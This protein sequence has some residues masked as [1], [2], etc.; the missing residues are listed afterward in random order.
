MVSQIIQMKFQSFIWAR[1]AHIASVEVEHVKKSVMVTYIGG[2]KVKLDAAR[3][4]VG[5]G[6]KEN[7][8]F[9][10]RKS[11]QDMK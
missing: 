9:A 7:L 11:P 5:P 10:K 6:V 2:Q 8:Q 4:R 3:R 1:S